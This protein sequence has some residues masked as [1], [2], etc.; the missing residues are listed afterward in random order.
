[1]K[2]RK[3]LVAFA[4]I[5]SS[6]SLLAELEELDDQA[7]EDQ[8]G[9]EGI[10][11]DMSFKWQIGEIYIDLNGSSGQQKTPTIQAPLKPV[12]GAHIEYVLPD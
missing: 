4:L 12:P 6:P 10:T 11:I 1:M 2:I 8:T 7:L 5:L 9:K 3:I